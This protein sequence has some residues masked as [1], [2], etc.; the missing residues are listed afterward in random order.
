MFLSAPLH[1]SLLRSQHH[2]LPL[3]HPRHLT[4]LTMLTFILPPPF[5]RC[6]FL[7]L[8]LASFLDLLRHMSVSLDPSDLGH[9]T[10]SLLDCLVVLQFL[11]LAGGF[12]A[13][14]FGSVG[15]P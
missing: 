12:D 8:D 13:F 7:G 14:A 11:A 4:L 10:V 15:S 6:Q 3:R 5:D 2:L 1:S 9:V